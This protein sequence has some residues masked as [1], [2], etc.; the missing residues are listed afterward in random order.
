MILLAKW[1]AKAATKATKL[2]H[3]GIVY[4]GKRNPALS[5]LFE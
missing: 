5:S 3:L 1:T 4:R 2:S